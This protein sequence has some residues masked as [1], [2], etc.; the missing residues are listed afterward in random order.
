MI[1]YCPQF[2]EGVEANQVQ[3]QAFLNYS[4]EKSSKFASCSSSFALSI[5]LLTGQTIVCILKLVW[6]L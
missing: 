3:F 6:T 1:T 4:L 5:G 2:Y